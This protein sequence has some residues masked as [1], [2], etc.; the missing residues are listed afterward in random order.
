MARTPRV[1]VLQARSL[2]SRLPH[3]IAAGPAV[4]SYCAACGP[5]HERGQALWMSTRARRSDAAFRIKLPVDSGVVA[6]VPTSTSTLSVASRPDEGNGRSFCTA[7]D[8]HDDDDAWVDVT[9]KAAFRLSS[10][11]IRKSVASWALCVCVCVC[12][13][14]PSRLGMSDAPGGPGTRL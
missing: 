11:F 10:N 6:A 7:G 9:P 13:C 14:K 4:E 2:T 1:R 12:L 5:W 3:A 8:V